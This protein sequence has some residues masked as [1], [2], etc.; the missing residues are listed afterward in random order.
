LKVNP[1]LIDFYLLYT[2]DLI[3]DYEKWRLG[4]WE[5]PFTIFKSSVLFE[6]GFDSNMNFNIVTYKPQ[7]LR[8]I[9]IKKVS[10]SSK[11]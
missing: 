5:H 2:V 8:R 6:R 3:K 4:K 9:D 11:F 1:I 7:N 10:I